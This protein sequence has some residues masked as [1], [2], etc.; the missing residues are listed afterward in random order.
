MKLKRMLIFIIVSQLFLCV[1]V[2]NKIKAEEEQ[3]KVILIDPGHGGIDGGAKSKNGTI[4]KDI[5]LSISHKLKK[6]LEEEGYKVYLTREDDKELDSRKKIDLDARCKMKKE[7]N[8]DVFISIHQNK[9]SKEK[10]KGAQ[11]WYSNNENSNKL[12][13]KMQESLKNVVDKNNNRLAKPARDQYRI[14]RDG[15]EGACVIVECGF[16]SNAEEEINLKSDNYQDKIVE[17]IKGG[18]NSYFED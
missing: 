6:I 11:V 17:G 9:F 3:S 13:T 14:L 4:E 1:V 15:Y 16:L 10:C 8:C 12:A 2:S 5:N 7:V 18:I